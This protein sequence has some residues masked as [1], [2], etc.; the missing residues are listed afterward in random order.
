MQQVSSL[1]EVRLFCDSQ[2]CLGRRIGFVPTMG[3]LHPGHLALV[4]RARELADVVVVSIFVNPTQF[5]AGEDLEHYPRDLP[6]DLAQCQ[7]A[8]ADVVFTPEA[9]A[10]YPAG[11]QTFVQTERLSEGLCG[12]RRPGH[13]RG[14][15]TV[16]TKFF[17]IIGPCVAV[18]GQKDYQQL[19]VIRRMAQDLD[20]PVEVVGL[21]TVRE[22]DGLAMSSRNAYLSPKERRSAT[23]LHR[24]LQAIANQVV[25]QGLMETAQAVNLA[26]EIIEEEPGAR[27]DYI[28]A[29][30]PQTLEAL[31]HLQPG[32]AVVAMAVFLGRT[33]LIDNMLI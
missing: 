19:Q 33:R 27:I 20:Q 32:R 26:R 16:V 4:R 2:R 5:G 17:N 31:T 13:F 3:Y 12:A 8:G 9:A 14:V 23:C 1:S 11:Y 22:P 24:A 10:M 18:F 6:A 28:E 7:S 21:E 29:R 15:C 30:D 25:T